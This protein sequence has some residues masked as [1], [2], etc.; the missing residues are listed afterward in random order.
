MQIVLIGGLVIFPGTTREVRAPIVGWMSVSLCIV[1][2]WFPDVPVSLW[3]G[4]G[5]SRFLKPLV[6]GRGVVNDQ[7]QNQF[8]ATRVNLR[9][10]LV[11]VLESSI[12]WVDILVVADVVAHV[13]SRRIVHW[14]E[15]DNINSKRLDVVQSRKNSG[16]VSD[17]IAVGVFVRGRPDLVDSSVLPPGVSN[18]HIF[19]F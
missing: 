17:T 7:V 14:R 6:F 3:V 11:H 1:L 13:I 9:N 8:H 15:P 2:W 10:Q 19:F 12:L 16:N 4:F 18:S 5:R